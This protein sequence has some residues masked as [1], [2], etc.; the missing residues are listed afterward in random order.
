MFIAD[1]FFIVLML[2]F[3]I[4]LRMRSV[5]CMFLFIFQCFTIYEW[6]NLLWHQNITS[7]LIFTTAFAIHGIF[8][9]ILPIQLKICRSKVFF[10]FYKA[11]CTCL[12]NYLSGFARPSAAKRI[13]SASEAQF[14]QAWSLLELSC[15]RGGLEKFAKFTGKHLCGSVLLK[16]ETPAQVLF[17]KFGEIL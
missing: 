11:K 12:E 16:K 17:C 4:R 6:I 10:L 3:S 9:I 13:Q 5:L 1:I 14:A 2:G 7:T 8:L 15:N